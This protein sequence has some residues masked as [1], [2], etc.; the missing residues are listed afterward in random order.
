MRKHSFVGKIRIVVLIAPIN[1]I[2]VAE[3]TGLIKQLGEWVLFETCHPG[4]N[5]YKGLPTINLAVNIS[6]VQ[7]RY[8]N[9]LESVVNALDK[10]GFPHHIWSW[11]SP[12][13]L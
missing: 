9:I 7:F 5:G 2:P 10:T 12:K 13:V 8:S 3:E 4:M 1:F 11:S 6:P